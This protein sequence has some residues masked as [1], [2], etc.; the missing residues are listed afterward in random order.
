MNLLKK[1]LLL[2]MISSG[3]AVA[4]YAQDDND[5]VLKAERI[6]REQLPPEV[7]DAFQKRFPTANLRD[8]MKIPTELYRKDFL[9]DETNPIGNDDYYTLT[10]TGTKMDV[11]AV[12][13]KNGNLIRANEI[14]RDVELPTTISTYI[15]TNYPGFEIKKDRVKRVIEPT[16]TEAFWEVTIAQSRGV[17]KRLL[18]NKDGNFIKSR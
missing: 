15:I 5:V 18:F 2:L 8:I 14:A 4:T 12:Y 3:M 10:M 17:E 9:I 7:L 1:G 11:E 16:R 6:K 13:D